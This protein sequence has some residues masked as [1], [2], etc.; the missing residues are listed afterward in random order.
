MEFRFDIKKAMAS[1]AFLAERGGGQVDMFLSLKA[2]YI[3]DKRAL[4][5]R[6]EDNH[7]RLFPRF[8][9]GPGIVDDL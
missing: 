1:V 6:G 5:Q 3:A 9:K 4:T 2:L 8:E 7:R